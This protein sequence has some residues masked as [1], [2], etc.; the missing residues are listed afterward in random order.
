MGGAYSTHA[1]DEKCVGL[2]NFVK[3][4]D[5]NGSLWLPSHRE[6]GTHDNKTYLR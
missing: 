5:Q 6:N 2:Q 4:P 1:E 3:K